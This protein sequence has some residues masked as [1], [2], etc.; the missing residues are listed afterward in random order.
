MITVPEKADELPGVGPVVVRALTLS[1]RMR[2]YK[3][4]DREDRMLAMLAACVVNPDGTPVY[5]A[6]EWDR[7]GSTI[8]GHRKAMEFAALSHELSEGEGKKTLAQT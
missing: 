2:V 1:Q 5:T 6:E 4:E 3:V 8:E 7:Y